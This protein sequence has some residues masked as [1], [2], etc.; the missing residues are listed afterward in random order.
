MIDESHGSDQ[1]KQSGNSVPVFDGKRIISYNLSEGE[2]PGGIKVRYKI[3]IVTGQRARAVDA[4]QA[5]VIKE[6]L[7]WS[8]QHRQ[9]PQ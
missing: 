2:R 6:V 5:Q 8:R 1:E 3:R 4:R 9:R 7:Q